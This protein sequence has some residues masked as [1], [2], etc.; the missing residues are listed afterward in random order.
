MQ[1]TQPRE[2]GE[3]GF[4]SVRQL[5]ICMI[6]IRLYLFPMYDA[7]EGGSSF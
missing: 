1:M 6:V 4:D 3:E 2:T 7:K 5:V